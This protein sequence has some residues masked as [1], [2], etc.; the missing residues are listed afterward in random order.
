MFANVSPWRPPSYSELDLSDKPMWMETLPL[1][2]DVFGAFALTYGLWTDV[3]REHQLEALQAV[4]EAVGNIVDAIETRGQSTNTAIIFTSD[5]GLLWGE[6]RLYY[7][8]GQPYDESVRVPLVIRYPKLASGNH[9]ANQ[10]ALNIDLAATI[11]DI[12][13]VTPPYALDGRSLVPIISDPASASGRRDFLY[14]APRGAAFDSV[15]IRTDDNWEYNEYVTGEE[16]LYDLLHDPYAL[17][18]VASDPANQTLKSTLAA[19]I[20]QL[21]Q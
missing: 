19:R 17:G 11:A 6:H 9:V 12:A 1:D 13:G 8:K 20:T 5:N 15:G 7:T 21:Q 2:S 10:M 4:D 16:E 3:F 18:S 14:E